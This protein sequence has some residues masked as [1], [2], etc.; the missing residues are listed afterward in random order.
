MSRFLN[1]KSIAFVLIALALVAG[2]LGSVALR[3]SSHASGSSATSSAPIK[4]TAAYAGSGNLSQAPKMTATGKVTTH[5]TSKVNR[6]GVDGKVGSS[7]SVMPSTTATLQGSSVT[8]QAVHRSSSKAGQ[9]LQSF[10]G[11]S[12]LDNAVT[13]GFVLTPPDQ[14]LCVGPLASF[15]QKVVIEPVN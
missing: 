7:A 14:G 15:G 9:L 5:S 11:V 6:K 2:A 1:R 12:D 13:T 3:G 4:G 8:G 10:D